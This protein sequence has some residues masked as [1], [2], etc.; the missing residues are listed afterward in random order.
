VHVQHAEHRDAAGDIAAAADRLSASCIVIGE[1][2]KLPVRRWFS[3]ETSTSVL[4]QA[5]CP[6]WYVPSPVVV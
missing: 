2:T 4:R 3:R 6:V 5:H 1:H